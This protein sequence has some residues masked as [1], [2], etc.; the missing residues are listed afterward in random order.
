MPRG[1]QGASMP[2]AE[3]RARHK[4][5]PVE[6]LGEMTMLSSPQSS[7]FALSRSTQPIAPPSQLVCVQPASNGMEISSDVDGERIV[8]IATKFPTLVTS[9]ASADIKESASRIAQSPYWLL[10]APRYQHASQT[11]DLSRSFSSTNDRMIQYFCSLL[12]G[13]LKK[14]E[15][16][17]NSWR[18]LC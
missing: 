8:I 6:R 9:T 4:G 10:Q 17:S 14:Q 18:T 3:A 1:K 16:L 5:L 13:G 11:Q 7:F 15:E 12:C 2:S